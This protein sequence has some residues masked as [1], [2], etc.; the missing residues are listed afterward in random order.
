M[1]KNVKSAEDLDFSNGK[2]LV[3]FSATWCGM[4][5]MFAPEVEKFEKA[6]PEVTVYRVDVDENRQLAREYSVTSIPSYFVYDNG[7]QV[8]NG[9]GFTTASQLEKILGV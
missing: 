9:V 4:C 7:T 6:H 8:R 2:S 5:V 1:I 3:V